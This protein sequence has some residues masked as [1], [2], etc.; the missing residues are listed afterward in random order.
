V[1]Q[2]SD[3]AS[4]P[5]INARDQM[6]TCCVGQPTMNACSGCCLGKRSPCQNSN[7][8]GTVFGTGMNVAVHAIG[9]YRHAFD[10]FG[11]EPLLERLLEG[12]HTK[13]T[14]GTGAG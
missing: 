5:A 8:V 14:I 1:A 4:V 10:R 11:S 12:F 13:D 9:G 6:W 3:R 2:R 7:Q